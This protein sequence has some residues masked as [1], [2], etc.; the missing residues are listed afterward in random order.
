MLVDT[1]GDHLD[2]L[3]LGV[4]SAQ[5][6]LA[7]R[8]LVGRTGRE[9]PL[10]TLVELVNVEHTAATRIEEGGELPCLFL[11]SGLM[12]DSLRKLSWWSSNWGSRTPKPAVPG[13]LCREAGAGWGFSV[14]GKLNCGDQ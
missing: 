3:D 7:H 8:A 4:H 9:R 10:E 13:S 5:P 12:M 14:F 11:L 2:H 6:A 1:V